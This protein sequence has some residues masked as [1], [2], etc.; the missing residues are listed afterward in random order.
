MYVAWRRG[1]R[2]GSGCSG[3]WWGEGG[4]CRLGPSPFLE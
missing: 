1:R 4:T 3:Y 2:S